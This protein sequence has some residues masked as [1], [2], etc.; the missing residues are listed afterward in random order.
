ME[1]AESMG[2]KVLVYDCVVTEDSMTVDS[3]LPH[4]YVHS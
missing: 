4:R 2:V 1:W 3:P